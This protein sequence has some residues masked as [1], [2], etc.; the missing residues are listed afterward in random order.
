MAA[1]R[2]LQPYQVDLFHTEDVT[3]QRIMNTFWMKTGVQA[4]SPPAFGAPIPGPSSTTSFATNI[5]TAWIAGPLTALSVNAEYLGCRVRAIM[6]YA[7][8]TPLRGIQSATIVGSNVILTTSSPHGFSGGEIVLIAGSTGTMGLNGSW[9]VTVV[10]A[11]T[12][13]VTGPTPGTY[14]G[15]A[16]AQRI[17]GDMQ[18]TYLDNEEVPDSSPGII[19]GDML[20]AYCSADVR[21]INGGT[22]RA[23]RS[24]I[25]FGP[26]GE[27][28]QAGGVLTTGAQ[29]VINNAFNTGFNSIVNDGSDGSSGLMFHYALSKYWAVLTATPFTQS[30]SFMAPVSSFACRLNL[31]SQVSRK[32]RS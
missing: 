14:L 27:L 32:A 20:P 12:F 21:R 28:Q 7:Y 15:G 10:D 24:R 4:V 19:T 18:F 30:F 26:L 11:V 2:Y 16:T 5:N 22:G 25:G 9:N 13:T 1:I 17:S 6:G 29:T 3:N 31:G 8:T 23:F